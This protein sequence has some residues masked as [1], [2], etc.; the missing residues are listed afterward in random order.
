VF[1]GTGVDHTND[2]LTLTIA[3]A[4]LSD[5]VHLLGDVADVA[6]VMAGFDVA[7][8]TSATEA[9]PNVVAEAMA[10]G[11]ANVVTDVGDSA[12][13]V[14]D[15]GLAVPHGDADA[16][17]DAVAA[18][19]LDEERRRR[20]AAAARARIVATFALEAARRRFARLWT[21]GGL[22]APPVPR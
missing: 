19:L 5:H 6:K 2:E 12:L 3:A 11:V 13:I 7:L 1:A 16:L 15:T 20:L 8:S 18:L 14:G 21:A 9:F 4:G 17:A 22:A 10:S